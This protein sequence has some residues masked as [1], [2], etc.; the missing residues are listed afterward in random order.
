[1]KQADWDRIQEIYHVARKLSPVDQRAYVEKASV[2]DKVLVDE[3]MELLAQD[4]ASFLE[5]P[6]A[7][8]LW[9]PPKT[10]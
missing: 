6:V 10:I 5:S 1:M 4:E 3:V 7:P 8:Y 2:G 9:F